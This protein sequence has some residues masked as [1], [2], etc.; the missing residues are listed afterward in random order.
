MII[1]CD[2]L[3]M[4][5]ERLQY[6]KHKFDF[7]AHFQEKE[8]KVAM[9]HRYLSIGQGYEERVDKFIE[10]VEMAAGTCIW[11]PLS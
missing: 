10:R 5:L 3:N 4:D 11:G 1:M 2:T 7:A 9:S 6:K 8:N